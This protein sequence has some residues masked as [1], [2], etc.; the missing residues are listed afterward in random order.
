MAAMVNYTGEGCIL[1]I[2]AGDSKTVA[3][4]LNL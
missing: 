3:L 1:E 2:M 4:R